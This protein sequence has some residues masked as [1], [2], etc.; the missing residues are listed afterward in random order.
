MKT[1]IATMALLIALAIPATS[2]AD[3]FMVYVKYRC[4]GKWVTA[5]Y[6]ERS[7]KGARQTQATFRAIRKY[8]N[9]WIRLV[10]E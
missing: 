10:R 2:H 8:R 6:K 7:L 3:Y 9:T 1:T 5:T 4:P